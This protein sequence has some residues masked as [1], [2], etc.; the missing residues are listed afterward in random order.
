MNYVCTGLLAIPSIAGCRTT[1]EQKTEET[2]SAYETGQAE[3][4]YK[5]RTKVALLISSP[6][7]L[8]DYLEIPLAPVSMLSY[9]ASVGLAFFPKQVEIIFPATKEDLKRVL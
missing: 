9:V 6:Q 5:G 7:K 1:I 8:I 2:E 4:D 3:S